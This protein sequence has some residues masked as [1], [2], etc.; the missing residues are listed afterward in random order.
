MLSM[1]SM[2][3]KHSRIFGWAAGTVHSNLWCQLWGPVYGFMAYVTSQWLMVA[4]GANLRIEGT[5]ADWS[6][7]P[8]LLPK[9]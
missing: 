1:P 8:S 5:G 4:Y 9:L 7:E 2:S 6:R 3:A